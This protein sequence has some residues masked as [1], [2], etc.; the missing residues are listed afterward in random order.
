MTAVRWRRSR[1]RGP[2][3]LMRWPWR[4][5]A[6]RHPRCHPALAELVSRADGHSICSTS[7]RTSSANLVVLKRHEEQVAK[8]SAAE[9]LELHAQ[10]QRTTEQLCSAFAP[11]RTPVYLDAVRAIAGCAV[12]GANSRQAHVCGRMQSSG[13]NALLAGSS[14]DDP[15]GRIFNLTRSGPSS[16][17]G[18]R[19]DL[20]GAS[21]IRPVT[22][23]KSQASS[24]RGGRG[25]AAGSRVRRTP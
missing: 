5:R 13:S 1:W 11:D 3:R 9:W 19:Y 14:S 22:G 17:V 7:T 20:A 24:P 6:W 25:A 2:T 15:T 12:R 4:E 16:A 10:V 23:A 18:K 21:S 8:L